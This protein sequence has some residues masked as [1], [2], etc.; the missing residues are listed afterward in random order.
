MAAQIVAHIAMEVPD[1]SILSIN[2][3]LSGSGSLVFM[4]SSRDLIWRLLDLTMYPLNQ[5]AIQRGN[6]T[7]PYALSDN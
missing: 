3:G 6:F 7:F 2:S 4:R 5:T 1:I